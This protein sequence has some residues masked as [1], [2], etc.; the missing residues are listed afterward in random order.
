[1]PERWPLY[2]MFLRAPFCYRPIKKRFDY[3]LNDVAASKFVLSPRGVGLDTYRLWESLYL[4]SY[5]IVKSSSLDPLY[6]DLPVVI[7]QEWTDVTEEFL[8]QKY[9]ELGQKTYNLDKLKMSY[10]KDL[11]YSFKKL[12]Q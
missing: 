1:M 6:R 12:S 9:E 11:I 4:G 2:Q 10:W 5:P 7:V 8:H 3:Y